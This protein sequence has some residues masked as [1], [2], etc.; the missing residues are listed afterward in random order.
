MEGIANV[1]PTLSSQAADRLERALAVTADA[2]ESDDNRAEQLALLDKRDALL[3]LA[4][5]AA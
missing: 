4:E 2:D 5:Q 1:L 3:A